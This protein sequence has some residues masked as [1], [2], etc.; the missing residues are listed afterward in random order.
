MAHC[1]V[2]DQREETLIDNKG[3]YRLSEE[4]ESGLVKE[5]WVI[6][7]VGHSLSQDFNA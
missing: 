4:R 3:N 6:F 2:T 7:Q 1:L 5:N